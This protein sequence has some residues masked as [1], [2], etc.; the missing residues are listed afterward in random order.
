[1]ISNHNL[2]YLMPD[3]V[4][5]ALL[6]FV[7]MPED[8]DNP[9]AYSAGDL[10]RELNT[11]GFHGRGFTTTAI[12]RAMKSIGFEAKKYRGT[13]KYI[14]VLADYDRRGRWGSKNIRLFFTFVR[15]KCPICPPSSY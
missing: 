11:R 7:R 1:M 2:P 13:Y 10:L 4:T 14:A 8:I 6:T 5:E 15:K 12:G 9:E 3:D